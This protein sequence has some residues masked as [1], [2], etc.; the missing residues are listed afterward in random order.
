MRFQEKITLYSE[1]NKK[2][3]IPEF[4]LSLEMGIERVEKFGYSLVNFFNSFNG[5][6]LNL[7]L[8]VKRGMKRVD[9]WDIFQFFYFLSHSF[10]ATFMLRTDVETIFNFGVMPFGWESH[11]VGIEN[12]LIDDRNIEESYLEVIY[13]EFGLSGVNISFRKGFERYITGFLFGEE[14]PG[15]IDKIFFKEE[16][17]EDFS[18]G[19]GII[20]KT[21]FINEIDGDIL[22]DILFL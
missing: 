13:R 21:G 19:D 10:E 1:G 4:I 11:K 3:V 17:L 20:L 12:I 5:G 14:N 2:P 8:N 6:D 16:D 22:R 18:G 7:I 9:M 15:N